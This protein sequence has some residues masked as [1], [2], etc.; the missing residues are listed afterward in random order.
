M[1]ESGDCKVSTHMCTIT[2]YTSLLGLTSMLKEGKSHKG[3]CMRASRFDDMNDPLEC[4]LLQTNSQQKEH[5]IYP[6]VVSFSKQNDNP[7]MWRLYK[8]Q[9]AIEIDRE[10]LEKECKKQGNIDPNYKWY[11]GDCCYDRDSRP[12][13][14]PNNIPESEQIECAFHKHQDF[15]IEGECRIM[16]FNLDKRE[17][18][19]KELK[20]RAKPDGSVGLYKEINIPLSCVNR[21]LLFVF[22]DDQ[23]EDQEKYIQYILNECY[24]EMGRITIAK[25]ECAPVKTK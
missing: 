11:M 8:A 24:P 19:G 25:T 9:V 4:K 21:I 10:A 22:D 12:I 13:V 1:A 2:H 6:Y 5:P 16:L 15:K 23:F 14:I 20:Y 18:P 7:V 17:D 3:L